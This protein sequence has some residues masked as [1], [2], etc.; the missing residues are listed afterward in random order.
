MLA[1]SI[2]LEVIKMNVKQSGI[3]LACIIDYEKRFDFIG[4]NLLISKLVKMG[5][6]RYI[7]T[8]LQSELRCNLQYVLD[9]E[10]LSDEIKQETGVPKER[11]Y[12]LYFLVFLL[13]IDAT[14]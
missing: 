12:H 5:L 11:N 2:M 9:G 8:T 6:H 10:T 4:R 7:L 3:I 13:L 1:E 14:N